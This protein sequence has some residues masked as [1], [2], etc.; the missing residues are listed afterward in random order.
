[1]SRIQITLATRPSP[2]TSRPVRPPHRFRRL[3]LKSALT[4]LLFG[5]VL[6]GLFLAALV[7]GSIIAAFLLILVAIV[8]VVAFVKIGLIWNRHSVASSLQRDQDRNK[9]SP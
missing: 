6:I 8:V 2:Q 4:A 7:L 1:M 3:N 5:S 9:T